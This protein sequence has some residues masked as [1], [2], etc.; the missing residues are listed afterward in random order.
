ML[1]S[2]FEYLKK[3]NTGRFSIEAN[4][5]V[6]S[7]TRNSSSRDWLYSINPLRGIITTKHIVHCTEGHVAH[8]LPRLR[9]ILVSRRSQITVQNPGSGF[10]QVSSNSWSLIIQNTLDYATQNPD[11]GDIIIGGGDSGGK[12]HAL[13]ISLN[14]EEDVAALSHLGGLLPATFGVKEWGQGQPSK[15]RIK[16]SW[17]GILC[18]PLDM[19][20]SLEDCLETRWTGLRVPL[21]L[22]NGS[23]LDIA[24]M[25]WSM[26]F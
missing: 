19:S 21:N 6:L 17:T 23:P 26:H 3:N 15:L 25:G 1:T 16:A 4:T 9:G 12:S 7:I 22:R 11:S 14:A 5:P 18:N 20:H 2:I 24:D 10:P 13:G 8:L